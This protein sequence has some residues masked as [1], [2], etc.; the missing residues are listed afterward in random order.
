MRRRAGL[1]LLLVAAGCSPHPQLE[2][3][4]AARGVFISPMGEPF[5]GTGGRDALIAR[6]FDGADADHDG[7][8]TLAEFKADA[9]RFFG[10]LDTDGDG[11]LDPAEL[12]HYETVV[13]P[14]IRV[15]SAGAGPR[16]GSGSGGGN[17]SGHGGGGRGAGGG[18]GGG[19]GGGS[20]AFAAAHVSPGLQGAAR[21]GFFDLPEPVAAADADFNRSI[22]LREFVAAA[23]QRFA[24]L[25]SDG[26]G[27][28]SRRELPRR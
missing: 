6:W 21:F 8:L 12:G 7:M 5:R 13:A 11:E 9:R 2:R 23:A 16:S 17:R 10:T 19:H 18:H 4:P 3:G 1:L 22:T 27:D 15:R 14:E 26:D 28:L 20:D 25:D 24:L